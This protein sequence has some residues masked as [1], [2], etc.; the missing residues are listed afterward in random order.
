MKKIE[1]FTILLFS[2]IMVFFGSNFV[3]AENINPNED[4][5]RYAYG[6]NVH[7]GSC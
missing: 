7:F 2:L 4:D 3:F 1:V 5:S 6:E